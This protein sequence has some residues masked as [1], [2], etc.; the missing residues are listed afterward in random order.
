MFVLGVAKLCTKHLM[1]PAQIKSGM[2][3]ESECQ[4]YKQVRLVILSEGGNMSS[5]R[6][7]ACQSK[8]ALGAYWWWLYRV[9]MMEC[10]G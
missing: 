5:V 8:L 1:W 9:A 10:M 7:N 4:A 6:K 2:R 3:L